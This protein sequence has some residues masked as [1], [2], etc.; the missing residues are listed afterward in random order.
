MV[1]RAFSASSNLEEIDRRLA[2]TKPVAPV[3]AKSA[4]AGSKTQ[5]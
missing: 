3:R 1:E 4:A 2:F 5:K